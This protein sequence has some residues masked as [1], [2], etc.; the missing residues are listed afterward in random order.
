MYRYVDSSGNR[1]T[2][3]SWRLVETDAHPVSKKRDLSLREKE[4]QIQ[5]DLMDGISTINSTIT[6]NELFERY[7]RTKKRLRQNVKDNYVMMFGK[8]IKSNYIGNMSIKSINKIDV[9]N[10]YEA[11]SESG[12]SNGSIH[13]MH[14]NILFPTFQFAVDNDW[15][16]KNPVKD[17]IKEYPYDPMNKR[18]ALSIK[19]Q[20]IF[21]EFIGKDKV[22]AKY[23]PI[24]VLILETALRRGEVLGLTWDNVDLDNEII[25]VDHQLYYHSVNGKYNIKV[26]NP[27][28]DFSNR[29]IPLSPKAHAILKSVKGAEYFNSIGSGIEINGYKNFVF[30]NSRKSN[31][32]IPRQFGDALTAACVKYNKKEKTLAEKEGREPELLPMVT[33][34]I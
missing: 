3:Y 16:R 10:A 7:I 15:L 19:E 18:E 8:H 32:I 34:H 6:L 17:C 4:M 11:M 25:M 9:L 23:Y 22:Y 26:G 28:T 2:E 1:K 12:L 30:L 14:N 29:I 24:V 21:T 20:K 33:P 31:V 27:K 13:I 5:K